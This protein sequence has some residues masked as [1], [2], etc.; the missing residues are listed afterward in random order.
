MARIFAISAF[1]AINR[2]ITLRFSSPAT[3]GLPAFLRIAFLIGNNIAILIRG[4][5]IYF[6]PFPAIHC[7]TC[8]RE[9]LTYLPSLITGRGLRLR[10]FARFRVCSKTQDSGTLSHSANS[11]GVKISVASELTGSV[12]SLMVALRFQAPQ[13]RAI[14]GSRH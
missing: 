4:C 5:Q 10:T 3:F 7:T 9:N 1:V 12:A 8:S 6:G 13:I 2:T 11:F 14:F